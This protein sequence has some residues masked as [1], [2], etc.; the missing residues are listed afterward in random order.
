MSH[1]SPLIIRE[2]KDQITHKA[3]KPTEA[4]WEVYVHSEEFKTKTEIFREALV[5]EDMDAVIECLRDQKLIHSFTTASR[6]RHDKNLNLLWDGT[7]LLLRKRFGESYGI[8]ANN[9]REEPLLWGQQLIDVLHETNIPETL[10]AELS[11]LAFHKR[12][13]ALFFRIQTL[14]LH[15]QDSLRF[16][17]LILNRLRH[18]QASWADTVEK[19][20]TL[21]AALNKEVIGESKATGQVILETKAALGLTL[22]KE[23]SPRDRADEARRLAT[24]FDEL[25]NQPDAIRARIEAARYYVEL[26]ARQRNNPAMQSESEENYGLALT[27]IEDALDKA[28]DINYLNGLLRAFPVAQAIYNSLG[29]GE[30]AKYMYQKMVTYKRDLPSEIR[31]KF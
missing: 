23:L 13:G 16:Q 10:L 4:G 26:A 22:Q 7:E 20:S 12:D 18:N 3:P 17:R 11:S 5:R 2:P 29:Q 25:G 19:D 30:R 21:A 9:D 28:K 1:E 24:S 31:E 6:G 8:L 15:G 14:V 27:L